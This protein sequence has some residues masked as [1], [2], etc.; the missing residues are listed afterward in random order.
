MSREK[1]LV[2]NTVVLGIG[3][4]L[5]K[6]ISVI[7]LPIVTAQL[8]KAEYGT[9]DLLSTLVMLVTPIAT[10]QIQSAAFRFLIDQRGNKEKSSEIITNILFVT[11]PISVIV[12]III[13]IIM[14]QLSFILRIII[15]LYFITDVLYSTF[16]QITRGLAMNKIYSVS[17]I[18]VSVVNGA[19]IVLALSVMSTGLTGVIISLCIANIVAV[20]FLGANIHIS[21]YIR[22]SLVSMV[23]IKE[24]VAYSWP[25]IPNNLSTWVL[26]LSDRLIITAVLGIEANAVYAVANKIPNMLSLAQSVFVMAWQENASIAV[27]DQDASAY[28]TKMYDKI[29]SLMFGFTALLIGFTPIMFWVLIRGDYD[30]AYY[31]IPILILGMFFYCMSAFQGGIYIAHKKTKSV[32]VTTML[33]AVINFVVNMLLIHIIGITAASLS[34]LI[35]YFL[36]YVY[37]MFDC[38]KF[39]KIY[40]NIKKQVTYYLILIIML[41]I[42]YQRNSYLDIINIGLSLFIFVYVN[43]ENI[44]VVYNKLITNSRRPN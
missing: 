42:C 16:A 29:L 5:P 37:R 9:Y 40:Y 28:Y 19:G 36:L 12:S 35:A 4:F 14:D 18:V 13:G 43:I 17:S 8:T 34:T 6:V 39:Q 24:L 10:L 21:S 3:K 44:K 11:V 32:G 26:S 7:T 25:M 1:E 41:I 20:I 38:L 31:Q 2:K 15:S 30:A 23:T 33:A 27:H 22:I